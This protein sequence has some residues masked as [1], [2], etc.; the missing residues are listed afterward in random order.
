MQFRQNGQRDARR[1]RVLRDDMLTSPEVVHDKTQDT[2][3]G[4][5]VAT[6][7]GSYSA[8]VSVESQPRISC[9]IATRPWTITVLVLAG[10]TVIAGLEAAFSNIFHGSG[11]PPE[12]VGALDVAAPGSL[13]AWFSSVLLSIAAVNAVLVY[14][15]RSHKLDDYKACYRVWL[16]AAIGLTIA[17]IDASTALHSVVGHLIANQFELPWLQNPTINGIVV[18]TLVFGSLAV[19]LGFEIWASRLARTW[20]LLA[21]IGYLVAIL[22]GMDVLAVE[23]VMLAAMAQ[24]TAILVANLSVTLVVASYCRYVHLDSQGTLKP[25]R[26]LRREPVDDDMVRTDCEDTSDEKLTAEPPQRSPVKAAEDNTPNRT[27]R[28]TKI[29]SKSIRC[30]SA[31]QV[32]GTAQTTKKTSENLNSPKS[33]GDSAAME[34]DSETGTRLSKSERRRLRKQMRRQK[35][36][37]S[38]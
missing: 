20:S 34:C 2:E 3:G 8:S 38:S 28:T 37:G 14:W 19:R 1:R 36:M 30:D 22:I 27:L 24:S 4:R 25:R 33:V 5:S 6:P 7:N 17:A 10:L 18:M 16:W 13:A 11:L 29:K 23:S 12:V 35:K 15:L 32:S 9:L 21:T 26:V 31:H